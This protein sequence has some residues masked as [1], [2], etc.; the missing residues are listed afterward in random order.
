MA[1][2]WEDSEGFYRALMGLS[3]ER[4]N[5]LKSAFGERYDLY[6]DA[7][8]RHLG[9]DRAALRF[10]HRQLGWL[11]L[12][13]DELHDRCG[14]LAGVW[15]ERGV[16]PGVIVGVLL[17]MGVDY[18]V[19][20]FTAWRLGACVCP[21][22]VY[23]R[24]YSITR[25]LTDAGPAFVATSADYESYLTDFADMLLPV[26]AESSVSAGAT[27][28]DN[29]S[30]TYAAGEVCALLYSPLRTEHDAPVE[31]S[32]D[33]AYLRGLRDGL[34]CYELG[35]GEALAAPGFAE[36][37]YQPALITAV[38]L[39]GGTYV[40]VS[41]RALRAEPGQLMDLPLGNLG[42]T[43]E[44]RD[45]LMQNVP[46]RP[47][48]WQRWFRNPEQVTDWTM[49]Q[50]FIDSFKLAKKPVSNVI[51]EAASGGALLCSRVSTGTERMRVL[52]NLHPAPGVPWTFLDANGSGDEAASDYGIFAHGADDPVASHVILTRYRGDDGIYMGNPEPRRDGWMYPAEEVV[53]AIADL[54]YVE[55]ASVVEV[56]S[57]A[58]FHYR[59]V[60]L[61][62]TGYHGVVAPALDGARRQRIERVIDGLV[63]ERFAP[64]QIRLIP[65][66]AKMAEGATDDDW[67]RLQFHRGSLY[68]KAQT[69]LYA[70]LTELRQSV[71]EGALAEGDE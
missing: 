63:G 40:H 62:F 27:I 45:L 71:R 58:N 44:V 26:S 12:T 6:H 15:V 48:A 20:L 2:S 8:V 41:M 59:F 3:G 61:V 32:C 7:V 23:G 38:F 65:L 55:G 68:R 9:S 60:L 50:D 35:V 57:G 49:W 34:L 56:P 53:A 16:E 42:I 14:R 36:L 24:D 52:M 46:P 1:T 21:V 66:F 13:F 37:Q 43:L 25:R 70:Q 64:D 29:R 31:L 10:M 22:P 5:S 69:P 30:Y 11:A 47:P 28:A 19:A 4:G 18:L 17:P 33:D 67:V 39:A 51:V 54:P